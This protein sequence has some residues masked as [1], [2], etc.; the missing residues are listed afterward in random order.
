MKTKMTT[1]QDDIL[2]VSFTDGKGG[3]R[4][5]QGGKNDALAILFRPTTK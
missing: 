4:M 1:E 2:T 5:T 3:G